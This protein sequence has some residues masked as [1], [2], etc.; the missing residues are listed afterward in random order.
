[1]LTGKNILVIIS[2]GIAAYK[3]LEVIRLLQKN[4]A[5]VTAILTKGGAQFVT[6]LSVAALT[7]HTVYDDLFDLKNETEMGHIRLSRENDLIVVVPASAN[8]IA[9]V[10]HGMADDLAAAV[11]LA[12][13]KNVMLCPAM[14]QEMWADPATQDNLKTLEAR[15]HIIVQP[16]SGEMACGETGTGRLQDPA[17]ILDAITNHFAANKP[18]FGKHV[19]VTSGPTYEPIDPVR[20]LGN[21]SSGKQGHAIAEALSD[22]GAQVTL[23]TGPVALSDPAH[24]ETIHVETGQQMHDAVM[25]ALPA[26]I[27]ICAA[28]VADWTPLAAAEAKIKKDSGGPPIL[29]LKENPDILAALCRHASRPEIVIGFAA[30][31]ASGMAALAELA[32]QKILRKECDYLCANAITEAAPVF[33]D[34]ENHIL[35]LTRAGEEVTHSDWGQASKAALAKKL[36]SFLAETINRS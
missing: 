29:Q 1:M 19:I 28:A 31:T 27:A 12:S 32:T 8:F 23:I 24:I 26:D 10:T 20:F 13:D 4:G 25:K 7:A 2:G 30:E 5:H 6:K 18:L 33:G 36:A 3:A 34:N 16:D 35:F 17:H 15:G 21:R 11:V 14:N 9:R 22:L